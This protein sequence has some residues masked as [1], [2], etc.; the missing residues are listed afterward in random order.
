MNKNK[1]VEKG[2]VAVWGRW[3]NLCKDTE[4]GS[5]QSAGRTPR[6]QHALRRV[7]HTRRE[8]GV[9]ARVWAEATPGEME[10]ITSSKPN[11]ARLVSQILWQPSEEQWRSGWKTGQ[12]DCCR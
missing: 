4:D 7:K 5:A 12:G 9:K 6:T 1:V 10:R 11:T 2:E 8:P 3:T